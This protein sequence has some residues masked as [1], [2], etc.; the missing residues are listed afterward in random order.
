M[1]LTF[2]TGPRCAGILALILF[3]TVAMILESHTIKMG[4]PLL[5]GAG[6]SACPLIC[7]AKKYWRKEDFDARVYKLFEAF[8][9]LEDSVFRLDDKGS[10]AGYKQRQPRFSRCLVLE[11]AEIHPDCPDHR[12]GDER[13]RMREAHQTHQDGRANEDSFYSFPS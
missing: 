12:V 8:Q 1:N 5:I 10:A 6:V 13:T 2:F 3:R 4:L 9:S 11:S 7:A